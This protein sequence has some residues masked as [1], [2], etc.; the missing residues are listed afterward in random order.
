MSDTTKPDAP[1]PTNA[2]R[3][4]WEATSE[5]RLLIPYCTDCE[6]YFFYPR[7]RC[8][9][10]MSK[11]V[12]YQEASGQGELVSYTTVHRPPT[13]DLQERAP[14]I[15]ALVRLEEGIQ[16]M[17]GIKAESEDDLGVGMPVEVT[18]VETTGV[19]NLPYFEPV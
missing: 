15:N 3:E 5:D 18:F 7:G 12:D 8:P 9:E 6:E 4:Y 14:Y 10:C 1:E 16:M 11:N 2:T 19:F 13:P 17:T